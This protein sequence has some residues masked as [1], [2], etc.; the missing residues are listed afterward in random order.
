MY[1][2]TI[3]TPN[4]VGLESIKDLSCFISNSVF[5]SLVACLDIPLSF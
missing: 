4:E 2:R 3:S 1:S 5:L